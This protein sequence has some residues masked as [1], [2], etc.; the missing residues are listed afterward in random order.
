MLIL[1]FDRPQLELTIRGVA[2]KAAGSV[3]VMPEV[4]EQPLLSVTVTA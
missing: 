3:M 2:V 1:A 4:T